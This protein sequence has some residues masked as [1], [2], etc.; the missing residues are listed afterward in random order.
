MFRENTSAEFV[1]FDLADYGH[2]GSFEAQ[3]QTADTGEQGEHIHAATTC[4][5][6]RRRSAARFR[7]VFPQLRRLPSRGFPQVWHLDSGGSFALLLRISV[8]LRAR[9]AR[10]AR[11][12]SSVQ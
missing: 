3:F 1:D 2:P 6:C 9:S 11:K 7:Q 4:F 8:S 10:A 12:Q 5:C